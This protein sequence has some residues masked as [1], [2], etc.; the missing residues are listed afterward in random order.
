[1]NRTRKG[2][3]AMLDFDE[4]LRYSVNKNVF[5]DTPISPVTNVTNFLKKAA[6]SLERRAK[7]NYQPGFSEQTVEYPLF[8]QSIEP[9][10]RTILDFGCVENILPVVLCN[11]GYDVHG[12]DFQDYPFHHP[13]FQ[14]TRA[15]I[16][17][18]DAPSA[19][20]DAVVSISTIEHVGLGYSGDPLE[21]SG[22][23]V[24][25]D[26]LYKS[27]KK[28]GRLYI[29]LPAGLPHIERGYRT[30]DSKSIRRLVPNIERLRFF[31]KEGRSGNWHEEPSI[32]RINSLRY[33]DYGSLF[34]TEAVAII[35]A[36]K[37]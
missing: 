14:F 11:L 31:M 37:K 6:R 1:M 3:Q 7:L 35:E 12:L 30:Y 17:A 21:T 36:R 29:T 9:G 19:K 25:V 22:D 34:P 8:Y 23:K 24:A 16:L 33:Q 4:S 2:E 32:K 28:N 15:D 18:W 10:V 20:F 5:F 26:K 13:N 27:L